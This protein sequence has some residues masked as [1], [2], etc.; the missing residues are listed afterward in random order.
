MTTITKFL[1]D[2]YRYPED[3]TVQPEE[4]VEQF[5]THWGFTIYRTYYGPGSDEQW[6]KLLKKITDGVEEGLT[7]LDEADEKPEAA[8]KARDQFRLDARSDP[9]TLKELT[10]E[11]VRQ[12]YLDGSGGQPMNTDNRPWRLFLL[13]DAQVLQ[14]PDFRL[15]KAAA[16]DYDSVAAVPKNTWSGPQRY[17]G[18]ITMPPTAVLDLYNE[19]GMFLFKQIVNRTSGGP[20]AFWDPMDD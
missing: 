7:E 10:L 9:T 15:L 5:L 13:A 2:L 14:D 12:L 17:F 3:R 20:G 8:V 19:L 6:S 18:W 11:D 1:N 16:A 4:D